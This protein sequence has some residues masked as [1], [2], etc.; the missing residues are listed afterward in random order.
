MPFLANHCHL[1]VPREIE[2]TFCKSLL[3]HTRKTIIIVD[4]SIGE[5]VAITGC[6]RWNKISLTSKEG[7]ESTDGAVSFLAR[8]QDQPYSFT[9]HGE[10]GVFTSAV[11][12][13]SA[14][15]S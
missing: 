3:I 12:T 5:A 4:F 8:W 13:R 9:W 6:D 7:M 15:A 11:K 2:A 10:Q 1:Q 14:H